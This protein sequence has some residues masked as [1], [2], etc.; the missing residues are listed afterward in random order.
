MTC[1][2]AVFS[3]L[4]SAVFSNFRS[5]CSKFQYGCSNFVS[6]VR[7]D[8]VRLALRLMSPTVNYNMTS[9]GSDVATCFFSFSKWYHPRGCDVLGQDFE[10]CTHGARL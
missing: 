10:R 1:N 2:I 3:H 9:H 6:L 8:L 7:I 5:I 4:P